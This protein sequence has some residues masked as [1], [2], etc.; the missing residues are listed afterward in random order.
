MEKVDSISLLQRENNDQNLSEDF[1]SAIPLELQL[2]IFLKLSLKDLLSTGLVSHSWKVL[3]SGSLLWR[4]LSQKEFPLTLSKSVGYEPSKKKFFCLNP[5]KALS[6]PPE[7]TELPFVFKMQRKG[8]F[9]TPLGKILG[10]VRVG[11]DRQDQFV[12]GDE[13]D[14]EKPFYKIPKVSTL[15]FLKDNI[16]NYDPTDIES[17]NVYKD[18][19]MVGAY[20]KIYLYLKNNL[21]FVKEIEGLKDKI[22]CLDCAKE[23]IY[24]GT[25][26]GSVFIIDYKELKIERECLVTEEKVKLTHLFLYED[27]IITVDSEQWI[28]VWDVNLTLLRTIKGNPSCYKHFSSICKIVGNVIITAVISKAFVLSSEE[29]RHKFKYESRV[30]IYSLENFSIKKEFSFSGFVTCLELINNFLVVSILKKQNYHSLW[31]DKGC[32]ISIVN[33]RNKKFI[34]KKKLDRCL[35]ALNRMGS[36]LVGFSRNVKFV[37]HL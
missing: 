1:I 27:K 35:I 23:K 13:F 37:W 19:I 5:K 24:A 26:R 22:I 7:K 28:K 20:S 30:V 2:Q 6:C 14:L 9:V 33:L 8:P 25:S 29:E 34:Y 16:Q 11:Q 32:L 18:M 4:I 36:R 31:D 10:V 21:Y 17:L 15:I 3:S 12:Y